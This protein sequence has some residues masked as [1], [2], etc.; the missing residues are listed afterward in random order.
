MSFIFISIICFFNYLCLLITLF[1]ILIFKKVFRQLSSIPRGIKDK[2][3]FNIL[4]RMFKFQRSKH[5][6][7]AFMFIQGVE[8]RPRRVSFCIAKIDFV[9]NALVLIW[10]HLGITNVISKI[11]AWV[12]ITAFWFLESHAIPPSALTGAHVSRSPQT[13]FPHLSEIVFLIKRK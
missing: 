10:W 5:A 7:I 13:Y 3:C 12:T 4:S 1:N 11:D 2:S 6:K 9:E 8:I